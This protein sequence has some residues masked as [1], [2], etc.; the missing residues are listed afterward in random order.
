MKKDTYLDSSFKC[1]VINVFV[2]V[3]L[4]EMI[5]C[6]RMFEFIGYSFI[7]VINRDEVS[8]PEDVMERDDSNSWLVV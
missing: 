6:F 2:H 4:V 8:S 1:M 7:V 3:E 5:Q